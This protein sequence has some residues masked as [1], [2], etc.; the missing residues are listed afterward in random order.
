MMV[1]MMQVALL[2]KIIANKD[3]IPFEKSQT[4]TQGH[5]HSKIRKLI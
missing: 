3:R 4:P 2:Y 5:S 1:N